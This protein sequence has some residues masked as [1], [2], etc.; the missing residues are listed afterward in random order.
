MLPRVTPLP[1][2]RFVLRRFPNPP[3]FPE[4]RPRRFQTL[5]P[6]VA[7]TRRSEPRG[8]WMTNQ[9]ELEPTLRRE[10]GQAVGKQ[11]PLLE[12]QSMRVSSAVS[13]LKRIDDGRSI[14][15]DRLKSNKN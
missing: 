2:T 14:G 9:G 8:S 10:L 3:F 7:V 13:S 6:A 15:N 12:S 11:G 5:K 1:G 4:S